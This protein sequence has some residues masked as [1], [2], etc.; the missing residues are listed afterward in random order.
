MK[1]YMKHGLIN[2][3]DGEG[4]TALMWAVSMEDIHMIHI[5]CQNKDCL[6]DHQDEAGYTALHIAGQLFVTYYLIG[7]GFSFYFK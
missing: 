4:R 2:L 7:S 6:L 3:E 5:L 1:V